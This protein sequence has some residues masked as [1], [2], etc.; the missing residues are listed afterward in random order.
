MQTLLSNQNTKSSSFSLGPLDAFINFYKDISPATIFFI[1]AGILAVFVAISV[2]WGLAKG[3]WPAVIMFIF[4]VIG[5]GISVFIAAKVD[6][7]KYYKLFTKGRNDIDNFWIFK[8]ESRYIIGGIILWC[9]M[10]IFWIIALIGTSLITAIF[11]CSAQKLKKRGKNVKLN[12]ILGGAIAPVSSL[13]LASPLIN[14]V[15]YLGSDGFLITINDKFLEIVSGGKLR[16][17]SR[18]APVLKATTHLYS[19][20]EDLQKLADFKGDVN[21][22]KTTARFDKEN[23]KFVIKL[24][25]NNNSNALNSGN[26]QEY[27]ELNKKIEIVNKVFSTALQTNESLSLLLKMTS[28][29]TKNKN[30]E[31]I[32]R[33][34]KQIE[35]VK[36]EAQKN[37]LDPT[38]TK[39]EVVIPDGITKPNIK[40]TKKQEKIVLDHFTELFKNSNLQK[41][42]IKILT[43]IFTS[44]LSNWKHASEVK[45]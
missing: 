44:S 22:D 30:D 19:N 32:S 26:N 4:I 34:A 25:V 45:A 18:L 7:N 12:R 11:G 35:K 28:F 3:F 38:K 40:L 33:Y 31:F 36:Q 17:Y 10:F 8:D 14:N 1:V 9:S 20:R 21:I 37:A 42:D 16:G 15:G 13:I 29:I 24:D 2:L 41:D 39:L 5:F 43:N 27:E 6:I 23:N